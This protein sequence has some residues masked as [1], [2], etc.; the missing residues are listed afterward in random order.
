MARILESKL[1][2]TPFKRI[3]G[4]NKEIYDKWVALEEEFFSHAALGSELLEQVRRVSAWGQNCKYW[5]SFS[6]PPDEVHQNKRITAA[7]SLVKQSIENPHKILDEEFKTLN[8][9]FTKEE[10]ATLCSFIA[11]IS[12]ANKFGVIVGLS[13]ED[14]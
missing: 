9:L 8:S 10:L 4:H 3:I 13:E 7:M 5:M 1:G 11:F 14:L 2:K 12:G 6:N